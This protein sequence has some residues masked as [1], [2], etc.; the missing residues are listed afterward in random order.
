MT[1][2]PKSRAYSATDA[3]A[4][5]RRMY[6]FL[7]EHPVGVI[8]SVTP[9]GN[10]HGAVIYFAVDER[11]TVRF[12]T[13]TGTRKYDNLVHNGHVMLTVFD[14]HTQTTA[15][16]AGV[17]LERTGQVATNQVATALFGASTRTSG[18]GLPP[19]VKLQAGAFTT[20]LIEPMQ[21]RMAV[22]SRPEVGGYQE[23]FESMESF[24]L[25][26]NED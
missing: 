16:I 12:L 14:A 26:G 6:D 7:R 17:A 19:I 24:E 15:Q 4:R 2:P 8:S 22:Y 20:F 10:P 18:S 23:L 5:R 1:Q 3:S 9:N 21:V 11:L 25:V 13:K